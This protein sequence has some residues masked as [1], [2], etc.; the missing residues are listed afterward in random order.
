MCET[1]VFSHTFD[2]MGNIL[3]SESSEEKI[4]DPEKL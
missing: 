3:S 2:F 1:K 4:D